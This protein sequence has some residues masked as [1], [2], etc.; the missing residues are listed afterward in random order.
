MET[1]EQTGESIVLRA[2]NSLA[3]EIAHRPIHWAYGIAWVA[4]I[5]SGSRALSGE[6]PIEALIITLIAF[7]GLQGVLLSRENRVSAGPE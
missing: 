3:T 5:Y 7:L 2:I 4:A 6:Y 1:T